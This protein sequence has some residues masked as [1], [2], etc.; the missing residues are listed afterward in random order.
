MCTNGPQ[1]YICVPMVL[2]GTYVY[3]W[4][5]KV[6]MCTNGPQ[7]YICVP[8]VLKGLNYGS[9]NRFCNLFYVASILMSLK[10]SFLGQSYIC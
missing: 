3:Q 1:R 2:K 6:H 8:M 10:L 7:R 4:S 5:S 9:C